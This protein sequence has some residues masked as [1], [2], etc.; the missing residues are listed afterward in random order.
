MYLALENNFLEPVNSVTHHDMSTE[1][2]QGYKGWRK[3]GLNVTEGSDARILLG[4]NLG[5]PCIPEGGGLRA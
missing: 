1:R 3:L 2:S 4:D 5:K